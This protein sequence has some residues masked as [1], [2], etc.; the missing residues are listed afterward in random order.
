MR[1]LTRVVALLAM[2]IFAGGVAH[3]SDTRF[4]K[5]VAFGESTT[6]TGNVSRAQCKSVAPFLPAA[7]FPVFWDPCT[8]ESRSTHLSAYFDDHIGN[9][10]DGRLS[11]GR[12]WVE[13]LAI[14]LGV[15]PPSPSA[16]GHGTNYAHAGAKTGPDAVTGPGAAY[17]LRV[18][19]FPG[20]PVPPPGTDKCPAG[21]IYAGGEPV[22]GSEV[23]HINTQVQQ[24]LKASGGFAREELVVIWGGA[25]DLRDIGRDPAGP[26]SAIANIVT[27]LATAVATAAG[28]GAKQIAVLNQLNAARAPIT[29]ALCRGN[30]ECLAQIEAGVQGFNFALR[31]ALDNLQGQLRQQGYSTKVHYVDVFSAGEAAVELSELFGKPFANTTVPALVPDP[32]HPPFGIIASDAENYLFW[33]PIHPTEKAHRIIAYRVCKTLDRQIEGLDPKCGMILGEH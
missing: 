7:G 5:I 19:L 33:D 27:N 9:G 3:G 24:H 31:V 6:D 10:F 1:P 14:A 12:V 13:F 16:N 17:N 21:K 4:A 18:N 8:P 28:A 2:Q 23:P 22:C 11:N 15:N 29:L 26:Q 30:A 32:K 25:N 20:N